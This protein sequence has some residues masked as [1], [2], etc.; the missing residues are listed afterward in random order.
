MICCMGGTQKVFLVLAKRVA[1]YNTCFHFTFVLLGKDSCIRLKFCRKVH[2]T[3]LGI[4]FGETKNI[5]KGHWDRL[6]VSLLWKLLHWKQS[7]LNLQ[8]NAYQLA[9]LN[10]TLFYN[11][12][13]VC[14]LV[15]NLIQIR[16]R[17]ALNL[18]RDSLPVSKTAFLKCFVK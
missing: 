3:L 18:F 7:S 5:N 1:E 9:L 14:L 10:N 4:Y 12:A 17:F 16:F 15:F 13:S 11:F 8:S 6:Q 2:Q